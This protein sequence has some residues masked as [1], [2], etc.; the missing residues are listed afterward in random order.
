MKI[1]LAVVICS[2]FCGFLFGAPQNQVRFGQVAENQFMGAV[3]SRQTQVSKV[4]ETEQA[5]RTK[6][7]TPTFTITP[8]SGRTTPT[9][10]MTRTPSR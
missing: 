3:R 7:I 9:P 10:T 5:R 6:T 8:T 1:L 4:T 2:V